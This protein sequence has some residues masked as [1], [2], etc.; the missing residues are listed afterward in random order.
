MNIFL[1]DSY[2]K[3]QKKK[4]RK[5]VI[6]KVQFLIELNIERNVF[7]VFFAKKEKKKQ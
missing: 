6:K 5:Q 7:L 1:S 3:M 2:S 4:P